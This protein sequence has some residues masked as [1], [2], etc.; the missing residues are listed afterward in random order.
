MFLYLLLPHQV[1]LFNAQFREQYIAS[2]GRFWDEL[3]SS[4]KRPDITS[5]HYVERQ[6]W[7]LLDK[8]SMD[9]AIVRKRQKL[10]PPTP[11]IQ[12]IDF[13][14]NQKYTH[15]TMT[16]GSEVVEEKF[17][18]I[19]EYFENLNGSIVIFIAMKF[20]ILFL[21][22]NQIFADGTFKCTP[23]IFHSVKGQ[24][25]NMHFLYMDKLMTAVYCFLPK[26]NKPCYDKVCTNSNL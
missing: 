24:I 3:S 21:E 1:A 22:A 6:G 20:I 25:W 14:G 26:K 13:D 18:A 12:N 8:V 11:T 5:S 7:L 10:E 9:R 15:V 23:T 4:M 19:N 16:Y 2:R 17:L